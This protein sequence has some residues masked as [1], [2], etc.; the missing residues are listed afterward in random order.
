MPF[1]IEAIEIKRVNIQVDSCEYAWK[2]SDKFHAYLQVAR[3]EHIFYCPQCIGLQCA[4]FQKQWI[5][6]N[7]AIWG[8][9][10]HII[11]YL[12]FYVSNR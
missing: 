8:K 2:L 11:L 4:M 10:Y 9:T 7:F 1:V 3:K 6:V 12:L 5:G